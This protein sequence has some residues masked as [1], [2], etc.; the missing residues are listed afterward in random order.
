DMEADE[1]D[2]QSEPGV[3]D[4]IRKVIASAQD[5]NPPVKEQLSK[6]RTRTLT[7]LIGAI[8]GGILLFVGIFS[9]PT[10]IAR[11]NRSNAG[12]N[13]GRPGSDE[14]KATPRS[15]TPLLN[16]DVG[17]DDSNGMEVSASDV[18]N[19]SQRSVRSA[20]ETTVQNPNLRSEEQHTAAAS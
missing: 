6:D 17:S 20:G 9:T 11:E 18:H 3:R 4:K 12:P 14:P 16:A 8:V 7:L 10:R 19:T 5:K 13:L 15:V 1:P 2:S